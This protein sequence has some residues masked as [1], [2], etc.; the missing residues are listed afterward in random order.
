MAGFLKL[1][2]DEKTFFPVII[3]WEEKEIGFFSRVYTSNLSPS[4]I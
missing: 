1:Q 2:W 4:Q 3:R